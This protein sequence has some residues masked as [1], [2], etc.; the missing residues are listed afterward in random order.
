MINRPLISIIMPVYNSEIFLKD[1]IT[2]VIDQNYQSFELILVDDGSTDNSPEI[3]DY[4]NQKD[5]RVR[6][7]H[8][9]NGG[10]CN[11]RN[12]GL[13]L[14]EGKY[15][16]FCDNDDAMSHNWFSKV[17]DTIEKHNSDIIR[18]RRCKETI[19]ENSVKKSYVK[20]Y[21]YSTQILKKWNDYLTAIQ[22]GYGVWTSVIKRDLLM[23]NNIS[24]D[25]STK[26]GYEDHIF[27]VTS[28]LYARQITIIPDVLYIWKQREKFSTSKKNTET[29]INNRLASIDKWR[30]KE[31]EIMNFLE[32]TDQ[33][34]YNRQFEYL[35]FVINELRLSKFSL[36]KKKRIFHQIK[37]NYLSNFNGS[38][39]FSEASDYRENIKNLLLKNEFISIYS[40][41]R[42]IQKK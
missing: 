24:F 15:I 17:T 22:P 13:K 2:S 42:H 25:E 20:E 31:L 21:S 18:F 34:K 10:I 7:I 38:L 29:A 28:Y 19:S 1:A 9:K 36:L 11:A 26:Y 41:G 4:F 39:F 33:E 37:T 30:N 14:A 40:L 27:V 32:A 35:K 3:C 8:K 16:G 23:N 12:A 5:K 6:V